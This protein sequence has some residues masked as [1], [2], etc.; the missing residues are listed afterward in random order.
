VLHGLLPRRA[1]DEQLERLLRKEEQRRWL[2][3]LTV[4]H[5]KKTVIVYARLNAVVD[6]AEL[7]T[8]LRR[9]GFSARAIRVASG[10]ES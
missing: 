6:V 3:S 9:A 10:A 2:D 8:A 7:M 4:H 5:V 1:A